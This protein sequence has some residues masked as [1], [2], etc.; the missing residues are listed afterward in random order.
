MKYYF[1]IPLLVI[2]MGLAAA[3]TSSAD[4]STRAVINEHLVEQQ[5]GMVI[6]DKE[7]TTK[8]MIPSPGATKAQ[9]KEIVQK[10]NKK[11][12]DQFTA[13]TKK[14]MAQVASFF[15][16]T[17]K[18]EK[19]VKETVRE[20]GELMRDQDVFNTRATIAVVILMGILLGLFVFFRTKKE[21]PAPNPKVN[22]EVLDPIKEAK[23]PVVS[24]DDSKIL[25]AIEGVRQEVLAIPAKVKEIDQIVIT[26][27]EIGKRKVTFTP[28]IEN[29]FH[30]SLR[31]PIG[32]VGQV[33]D[34]SKITR[35]PT[36]DRGRLVDTTIAAFRLIDANANDVRTALTRALVRLAI[37]DGEIRVEEI[38]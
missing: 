1:F 17:E 28:K 12:L 34:P 10:E 16:K 22:K 24:R 2:M 11:L 15:T 26:D 33:S 14:V 6:S 31:I 23:E 29:N 5:N 13:F 8:M 21:K 4:D 35:T 32:K 20:Q 7:K 38:I 36:N 3:N 19:S 25:E 30:L 18:E 37:K 27:L 9:V